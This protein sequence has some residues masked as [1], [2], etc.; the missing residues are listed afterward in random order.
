MFKQYDTWRNHPSIRIMGLRDARHVFPGFGT[1]ALIFV[2]L[3]AANKVFGS[4]DHDDHHGHHAG[5]AGGHK[6][7]GHH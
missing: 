4:R 2:T 6:Q 1:A 7:I 5:G 3:W